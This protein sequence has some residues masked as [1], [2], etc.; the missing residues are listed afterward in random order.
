MFHILFD[1]NLLCI[2]ARISISL[3]IYYTSIIFNHASGVALGMAMCLLVSWSRATYLDNYWMDC[4][5][6]FCTDSH[7]SQRMNPTDLGDPL[8]LPVMPA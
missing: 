1:G 5:Y 6:I 7:G 4:Y 8:T 3:R 2:S